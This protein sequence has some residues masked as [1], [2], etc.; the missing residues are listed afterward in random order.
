[1]TIAAPVSTGSPALQKMPARIAIEQV[2]QTLAGLPVYIAGSAVAAATYSIID[3]FA[4]DDVDVF[5]STPNALIASAQLLLNNGFVLDDKFT[6]VWRRWLKYGT[7]N[8]HTNS[9]KLELPAGANLKVNLVYKLVDGHPTTSLAQV[10]ESFDF[11]LLAVGV[12]VESGNWRDMRGYLFPDKNPD[13]PLP[14]MPNKQSNWRGGFISQYN[15]LREVG[16]YAKYHGYGFDMSAVKDDLVTGYWACAEYLTNRSDPE[17]I[18]LGQIY[19]SIA[20]YME[21]DDIVKLAEAG[22]EILYLDELDK[23]MEALE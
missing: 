12:D 1:M 14:L 19:E 3:D 6:K 5:C 10:I 13:G 21:N 9:L 16:R 2:Q 23:I 4:Y 11:G 17:K 7:K 8:W 20:M 15:G 18:Q 22:A